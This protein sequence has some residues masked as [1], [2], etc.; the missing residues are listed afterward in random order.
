MDGVVVYVCGPYMAAS[1]K[2]VLANIAK[3]EAAALML[4]RAGFTVICPHLNAPRVV[5]RDVALAG[6]L[7]LLRRC[8]ALWMLPGWPRSEGAK[9]EFLEAKHR[10][11]PTFDVLETLQAWAATRSEAVA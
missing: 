4:W 2:D 11:L 8:D 7:K 1:E 5:S 9:A 10:G 6:D 3:A